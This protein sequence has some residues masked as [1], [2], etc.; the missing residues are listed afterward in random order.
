[1]ERERFLQATLGSMDHVYNIARRVVPAHQDARDLVQDT[2]LAAFR[3]W[4]AGVRPRK[5]EAW[6][7]TICL[8][9][10]RS[11]YRRRAVRPQ[12]VALDEADGIADPRDPEAE[13]IARIDSAAIR[14][15]LA[16]L[17]EAQRIAITLVDLAGFTTAQAAKVMR[18]PRG[19]VQSRLHRGRRALA[20]LVRARVEEKDA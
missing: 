9:L 15:A 4:T 10:A 20:Q 5:V 3:A 16:R 17:P 6:L 8:N 12:E 14:E 2:Y 7:A 11:G 13:A 1:M 19:T 18:T